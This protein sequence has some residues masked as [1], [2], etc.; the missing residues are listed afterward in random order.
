MSEKEEQAPAPASEQ[1]LAAFGL[2]ILLISLAVLF[3]G[4]I[5][6]YWVI[7]AQQDWW[8][9]GLPAIPEGFWVSTGVLAL[10]SLCAEA[11]GHAFRHGNGPQFRKFFRVTF[12]L[13]LGF[14][15][16]QWLTWS[17]LT[18]LHLSPTTKSLYS[19]SIY[20]LTGLHA[21][22]VVGGLV[23]HGAV[24]RKLRKEGVLR[25]ADVRS[26]AVYWHFLGVCWIAL[27]GTLYLGVHPDLTR[28]AV[29]EWGMNITWGCA[30]VFALCW[31]RSLRAFHQHQ[32]SGAALLGLFLPPIAFM[33]AVAHADELRLRGTIFWWCA[34]S[35][36][37]I[38]A[39]STAG[40][41]YFAP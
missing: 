18:S 27:F 1:E 6:A 34:A 31:M 41:V 11:M 33:R 5:A 35:G 22:H 17:E 13:A 14:S 25:E 7:R 40:A 29:A 20:F 19:F 32:G 39:L 9:E 24:W 12:F 2:K 4:S 10:L 28:E 26:T 36:L 16:N 38:A 8:A 15:V 37:A 30:V 23:W 3:L 21:A